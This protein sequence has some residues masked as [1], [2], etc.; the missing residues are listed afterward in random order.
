VW[1]ILPAIRK[2]FAKNL[3]K[4]HNLTQRKVANLLGITEAAVSRYVSGKRGLLE[5]SDKK[6][7]NE[8]SKSSK[9][10]FN[11]NNKI[12]VIE[13]CRICNLLK[14]SELVKSII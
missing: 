8:I 5:I 14:S 7:L 6:I 10:I 11:G 4:D 12:V 2:E 3:I 1:N 13:I 9:R